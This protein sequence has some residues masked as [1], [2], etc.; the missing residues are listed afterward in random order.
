MSSA[1]R[2]RPASARKRPS[3]SAASTS[4]PTI[5]ISYRHEAPTTDIAQKLRLALVAP[6]ETWNADV[7]MDSREIRPGTLFDK[8]IAAALD[9]TTH[10]IVLLTNAYWSSAY[11]RKELR[12]ALRRFGKKGSALPLFVKAEELDPNHF[13]IAKDLRSGR[14]RSRD[15]IIQKIGDIQFLGPF[16]EQWQ[17]V[18][19]KWEQPAAL[20]DQIAQLVQRLEP[21]IER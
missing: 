21:L 4:R 11:C 5:F 7:F 3:R 14:I 17:L 2:A 12:R 1:R 20:A 6:A 16:N 15:A 19:L 9:R 18:R 8:T 13:T 10:F